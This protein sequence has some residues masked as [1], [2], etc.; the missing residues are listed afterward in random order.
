M[1]LFMPQPLLTTGN[2]KQMKT[3]N[4]LVQLFNRTE[5]EQRWTLCVES[6]TGHPVHEEPMVVAGQQS[7]TA[8]IPA[9][10]EALL[11]ISCEGLEEVSL[12]LQNEPTSV[13]CLADGS[14]RITIILPSDRRGPDHHDGIR[15]I[16]VGCGPH[17]IF[18]DWWNVDVRP[19]PGVDA[20]FDATKDW[21]YSGLEFIYGEHF[22]EHLDL[23]QAIK[24]LVSAG[25]SLAPGGVLRLTTPNLEWV[26]RSHYRFASDATSCLVDT[27]RTNRAFHGWGHKFLYSKAMVTSLFSAIGY[28][29]V[30]FHGY[31]QSA[32]GS[33][34]NLE[35]HGK[36]RVDENG[37]E[38]HLIFEATPGPSI[39]TPSQL[40]PFLEKEFLNAFRGGH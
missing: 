38:N 25:K 12:T 28:E 20:V 33:L 34:M 11:K 31:G 21:P 39:G 36:W 2:K 16:Q 14:V 6:P 5:Q 13:S 9:N 8:R 17:N 7:A 18:P 1:T 32:H 15:K 26:M 3:K 4:V 10:K 19:F 24:F 30:N 29:E 27:L 37:L 23:D 40:M 22:L 35:R